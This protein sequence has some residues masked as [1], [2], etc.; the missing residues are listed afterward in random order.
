M[1]ALLGLLLAFTFSS[2]INKFD[3][4]RALIIDQ[5]NSI[6]TLYLRLDLLPIEKKEAIRKILKT[7]LD[8][9]I[10]AYQAIPD[11]PK[12]QYYLKKSHEYQTQVWN[13]TLSSC[14]Q[15]DKSY[16]CLLLIP[17]LNQVLDIENTRVQ[18]MQMHPPIYIFVL[19]IFVD[20][21][22]TFFIGSHIHILKEVSIL[23]IA[24]YSLVISLIIFTIIDME[25]PRLG[26]IRVDSF[27]QVLINLKNSLN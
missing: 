27:D 24:F 25:Y 14:K 17:A 6:G 11:I 2:A 9:H 22:A 23:H 1:F 18:S 4:R 7:Y 15:M 12:A 21:V 10:K 19:L 20:L 26:F 13:K 16:S 3:Q 5:A 8:F